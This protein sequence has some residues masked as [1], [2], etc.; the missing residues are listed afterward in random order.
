M[1][2]NI[3]VIQSVYRKDNPVW[4]ECSIVSILKQDCGFENINYYLCIDGAIGKELKIV[5]EKYKDKFYKI[6]SNDPNIGLAA[7]LN[8]LINSLEY[9][10]YIFRM[11]SD[12]ISCSER[13]RKQ[14]EYLENNPDVG[15][16]GTS[17]VEMYDN[18]GKPKRRDYFENHEKIIKNM[19]KGTA[20]A[21]P[22]V[23]YKRDALNKLK[24]YDEDNKQNEDI[25]MWF[26]A[27][28]LGIKF[29]NIREPLYHQMITKDFYS[30]RSVLK[31]FKEFSIY[32]DGC[33]RLYGF[34][35]R[36]FFPLLRLLSRLIPRWAIKFLYESNFRNYLFKTKP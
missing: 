17:L 21:H 19:Y 18:Y 14:I 12:D 3:A 33:N 34:S 10:V 31:A 8:K 16:C 11:D 6:V 20:A 35:W 24:G 9:E 36:N 7:S 25:E 22:T 29:H 13:F 32:W 1:K 27:A 4:F 26:R 15:I 28:V 23:C 30:R 5:V 2:K